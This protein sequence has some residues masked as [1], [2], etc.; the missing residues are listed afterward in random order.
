MQHTADLQFDASL[1]P[2]ALTDNVEFRNTS[3]FA[4]AARSIP[5]P[6]LPPPAAV[7]AERPHAHSGTVRY[8]HLGL[9]IKFGLAHKVRIEEAQA[10]EA[11]RR[12]FPHNEVPVPELYGWKSSAG[13]HFIYMSLVPGQTL[14]SVWA[15][16]GTPERESIAEQLSRV[17]SNLRGLNQ[18]PAKECI[19]NLILYSERMRLI[20]LQG[21]SIAGLFVISTLVET[22]SVLAHS[23]ASRSS[24][25][26]STF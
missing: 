13:Y 25:T 9:I 7:L 1:L 17:V 16:L 24:M 18:F 19:G 14:N 23:T 20:T 12:A 10:L 3:Y 22:R 8:E 2:D 15:S 21:Q 5:V 6:P 4:V 11:V 26:W